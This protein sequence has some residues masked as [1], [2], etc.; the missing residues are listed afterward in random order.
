[1]GSVGEK[2]LVSVGGLGLV[3]SSVGL[4]VSLYATLPSRF[5]VTPAAPLD[6]ADILST[7]FIVENTG[8]ISVHI[9]HFICFFPSITHQ[10]GVSATGTGGHGMIHGVPP[11]VEQWALAPT[12]QST[13]RCPQT[14]FW[15]YRSTAPGP[16]T[17]AELGIEVYYQPIWCPFGRRR[18]QIFYFTTAPDHQGRLRWL[19]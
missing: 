3:V 10:S 9:M 19:P 14:A 4:A 13:I 2:S 12:K 6:P 1:M 15:H 16:L 11:Q 18:V 8:Y 5:S 7:P 17:S